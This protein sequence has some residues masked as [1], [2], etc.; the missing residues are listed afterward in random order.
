MNLRPQYDGFLAGKPVFRKARR[1]HQKEGYFWLGIGLFIVIFGVYFGVIVPQQRLNRIDQAIARLKGLAD[2][3]NQQTQKVL[4]M[5]GVYV[6]AYKVAKLEEIPSLSGSY[7]R[8]RLVESGNKPITPNS[9]A[10]INVPRM[11][12]QDDLGI[13]G[14]DFVASDFEENEEI[15]SR[16]AKEIEEE[17]RKPLKLSEIA[18][19]LSKESQG[20]INNF[21]NIERKTRQLL[22]QYQQWKAAQVIISKAENKTL[23]EQ[24]QQEELREALKLD[25]RGVMFLVSGA[26]PQSSRLDSAELQKALLIERPMM[27]PSIVARQTLLDAVKEVERS[28]A[29]LAEAQA[30][31]DQLKNQWKLIFPKQAEPLLPVSQPNNPVNQVLPN[32]TVVTPLKNSQ[33]PPIAEQQRQEAEKLRVEAARR[34]AEEKRL[35]EQ[36]QREEEQRRANDA[37]CRSGLSSN[38]K[39]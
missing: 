19:L 10:K 22:R 7:Q 35:Q 9:P 31:F 1:W 37:L 20:I 15:D 6:E 32:N 23:I 27:K 13:D 33:T 38:C 4:E 26:A 5:A 24:A 21:P 14:L 3:Y 2:Q 29:M 18:V 25:Y 36:R 8:R 17:A 34:A 39:K 16:T 12:D 11:A 28:Q 30:F